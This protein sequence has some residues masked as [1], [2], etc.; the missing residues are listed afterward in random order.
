MQLSLEERVQLG[1]LKAQGKGIREIGRI[2]DRDPSTISRELRRYS[3]FGREIHYSPLSFHQHAEMVKKLSRKKN[4]TKN[5][6]IFK[7]VDEKLKTGW[8][9]E[10]ISG[11]IGIDHPG[12][13]ICFETIYKHVYGNLDLIDCLSRRHIFRKPRSK[14]PRPQRSLIPYRL[15]LDCR[16]QKINERKEFGHW[17]SDTIVCGESV[18]SINNLVE[19]KSRL[20]LLTKIPDMKPAT[21]KNVI[22]MQLGQI[23]GLGRKSITYDNGFE[24]REHHLINR[25]FRMQSYF[26]NPYHSWE[27]GTV[28][29]TNGLVRR[30]IPKK[31]NLALVTQKDLDRIQELLNNRPRKC[32]G[33]KTPH[34]VFNQFL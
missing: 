32:L 18:E 1:M 23:K 21:T 3:A 6:D 11:R 31:M 2:L 20:T 33:Y 22:Q 16:S 12:W 14:G 28:E 24:N 29:N 17:E 5:P 7:Y 10:Q 8:S 13:S 30:F 27:K 4:P 9:P 34:E 25:K 26:C 15:S 19:R